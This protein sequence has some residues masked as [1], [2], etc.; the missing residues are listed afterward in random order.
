MVERGVR[1]ERCNTHRVGDDA[2]HG[3]RAVAGTGVGQG[4][5]NGG[6]GVEQIIAGHAWSRQK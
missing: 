2:D 5:H 1:G 3:L 4:G 6:V